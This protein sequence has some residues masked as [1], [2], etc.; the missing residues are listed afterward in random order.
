MITPIGKKIIVELFPEE[1]LSPG[2][3]IL[4]EIAREKIN[5][6]IVR[7]SKIEDIQVG[8][9]ILF[10]KSGTEI[11]VNNIKMVF[12]NEDDVLA[13]ESEG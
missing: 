12:I 11:K 3:I 13:I 2:G 4:P 8:E 7:Y 10:S 5:K 6:G 9:I 1:N